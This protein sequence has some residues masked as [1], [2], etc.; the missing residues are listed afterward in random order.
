MTEP[1]V[2][3]VVGVLAATLVAM[4]SMV[5]RLVSVQIGRLGDRIDL[6]FEVL[7]VRID[8]LE[9][10]MDRFETRM[11]NF[12]TRMDRLESRVDGIDQDV[13]TI[14]KRIFGEAQR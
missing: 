10:R 11:D 2:W 9:T 4:M 14:A 6:K 1:Q 3:A 13:Q 5:L 7:T 8:G 12:E